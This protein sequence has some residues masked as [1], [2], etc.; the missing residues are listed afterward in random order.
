MAQEIYILSSC[1]AWAGRDS[2]RI[3]GVT[4]DETML[5]A[6]LAAKIKAGDMEYSGFSGEE[7]YRIF[8]LIS[9]KMKLILTSCN[10]A[11]CRPS[12]ICRLRNQ[13]PWQS[14]QKQLMPTRN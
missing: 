13:F 4:T 7:A 3:Q 11:L 6:M 9:K 5:Y 2:M 14:F 1:D 8:V 10:T 12:R